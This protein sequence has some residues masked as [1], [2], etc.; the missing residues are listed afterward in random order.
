MTSL[1]DIDAGAT[2]L[3]AGGKLL[4]G[5]ILLG[6]VYALAQVLTLETPGSLAQAGPGMGVFAYVK[7]HVFGDPFAFESSFSLCVSNSGDWGVHDVLK[8][9][10]M[11]LGMI[12]AMMLPALMPHGQ[13][14]TTPHRTAGIAGYVAAWL[15]FCALAVAAQWGM[16]QAGVLSAHALLNH[17]GLRVALLLMIAAFYFLRYLYPAGQP[18][19]RPQ[20]V[21]SFASGQAL[22]RRCQLCCGPLM[23]IMFVIGLMNLVGM[24]VLTVLML[25]LMSA[26]SK[27]ISLVVSIGAVIWAACIA[28]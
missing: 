25:A 1:P 22:G 16:Q 21:T 28:V 14:E 12:L 5:L 9:L 15:P 8:A 10:A 24:V 17:D 26:R 13:P 4:V 2:S 11:W 3:R 6:W 19:A 20:A 27:N 18:D 7:A 23:L